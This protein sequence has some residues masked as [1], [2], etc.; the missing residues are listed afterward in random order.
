[1]NVVLVCLERH[2]FMLLKICVSSCVVLFIFLLH[3]FKAVALTL[4]VVFGI[5]APIV[6][7]IGGILGAIMHPDALDLGQQPYCYQQFTEVFESA[8]NSTLP[9]G[10]VDGL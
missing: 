7:L 4:S 10:A 1:M 2:A 9:P 5:Q 6:I 3:F 8:A